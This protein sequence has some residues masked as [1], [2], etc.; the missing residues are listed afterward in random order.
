MALPTFDYVRPSDLAA[1]RDAYAEAGEA[2]Y[3]AGGQTLIPVMKQRLAQPA[4]VIDLG[5]VAD[6]KGIRVAGGEV[7]IGAMTCHAEVAASREVQAQIPALASLAGVIGD[8]Q[9]RNR[10][11]L[12]G[13]L[14]NND[15]SADYPA[16]VL[17]LGAI[18]YTDSRAIPADTFFDGLFATS[19]AD[20]EIITRVTFPVPARAGYVKF[21]HPAS[22]FALVGVMVSQGPAGV[23]VAATGAGSG[24][25]FRVAAMEAVLAKDFT[26]AALD[27]ISV[28]ADDMIV[29]MHATAAYRAHLVSVLARRAVAEALG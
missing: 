17:G 19:L 9:V 7:T 3:L 13:S 18:V 23:R 6:L 10:G 24:G 22:R 28:P 2:R 11:T 5:G 15:P 4:A 20:G 25:V 14:A 12:G 16:A 29:D 1:A 26:V 27:G 8:P 21:R